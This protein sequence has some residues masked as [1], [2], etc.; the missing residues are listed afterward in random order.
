MIIEK[1]KKM[2]TILF[3]GCWKAN[4]SIYYFRLILH[5]ENFSV[6]LFFLLQRYVSDLY[7]YKVR[8]E[9]PKC[10]PLCLSRKCVGFLENGETCV[11]WDRGKLL[12]L[13]NFGPWKEWEPLGRRNFQ[14]SSEKMYLVTHRWKDVF[15][16]MFL[17]DDLWRTLYISFNNHMRK[18]LLLL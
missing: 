13:E 11:Q 17:V 16:T 15:R 10:S 18:K 12:C 3:S 14:I 6:N 8:Q 1:K 7:I 4:K 5:L 2:L 9:F